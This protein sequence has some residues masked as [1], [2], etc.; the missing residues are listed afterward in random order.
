MFLSIY[1]GLDAYSGIG[2]IQYRLD[3]IHAV[4]DYLSDTGSLIVGQGPR[5]MKPG[6][7][8]EAGSVYQY[9]LNNDKHLLNS[10]SNQDVKAFSEM[11]VLGFGLYWCMLVR[12]LVVAWK[13]WK[14]VKYDKNTNVFKNQAVL[15]LSFF[16]VW[17]FYSSIGLLFNDLWRM[18]ASSIVFWVM[19]FKI[20]VSY[21]MAKNT[22]MY[23]MCDQSSM[24]LRTASIS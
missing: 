16:G 3:Y 18:D 21:N 11:G 9:F 4:W 5:S 1:V 7:T 22:S 12:V 17:F 8:S 10:G 2:S 20:V 15:C 6:V 19:S 24:K 13:Y 14:I 23:I